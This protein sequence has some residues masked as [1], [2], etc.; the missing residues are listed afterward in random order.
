M[1]VVEYTNPTSPRVRVDPLCEAM[2]GWMPCG[3]PATE[4]VI[5]EE[6]FWAIYWCPE[7]AAV[8]RD[9]QARTGVPTGVSEP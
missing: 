6:K 8:F 9:Y 5:H 4:L 2:K 7:H 1:I 3:K